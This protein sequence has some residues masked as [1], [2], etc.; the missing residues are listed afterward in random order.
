MDAYSKIVTNFYELSGADNVPFVK[1]R[2]GEIRKYFSRSTVDWDTLAIPYLRC[3][4][5]ERAKYLITRKSETDRQRHPRL[6]IKYISLDP[7]D[8]TKLNTI[9]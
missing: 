1:D 6:M 8:V 9:T 2:L 5:A 4:P 7:P 3:Q